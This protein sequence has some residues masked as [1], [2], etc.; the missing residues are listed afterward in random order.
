MEEQRGEER[1]ES[2]EEAGV[3]VREEEE[4]WK[5]ERREIRGLR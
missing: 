2:G 1:G 4:T 3:D 5:R